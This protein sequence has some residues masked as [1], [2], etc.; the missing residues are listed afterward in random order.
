MNCQT[1]QEC[2]ASLGDGACCLYEEV[3]AMNRTQYN[4][5]NKDFVDYY[6]NPKNYDQVG[7]VWTNPEDQSDRMT[8]Y[9]KPLD[10]N[11]LPYTYPFTQ[12]FKPNYTLPVLID[13]KNNNVR[14]DQFFYPMRVTNFW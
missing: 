1:N 14:S 11:S 5:R 12:P 8:V 4:C 7:L 6:L 9:C 2:A 13:I 3:V 10:V